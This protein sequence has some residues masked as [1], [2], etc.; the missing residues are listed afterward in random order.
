[1]EKTVLEW[2]GVELDRINIPAMDAV[3]EVLK[4]KQPQVE[5]AVSKRSAER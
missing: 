4:L 3:I 2:V 1:L 5:K